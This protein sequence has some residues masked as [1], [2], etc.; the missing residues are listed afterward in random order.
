MS[1]L[2]TDVANLARAW[3]LR[4]GFTPKHAPKLTALDMA[5]GGRNTT[6]EERV[7]RA[8]ACDLCDTLRA[9]PEGRQA[10]SDLGF[11]PVS[12]DPKGE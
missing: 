8:A 11:E 1:D 10:L 3:L 9:A 2:A 12:Q 5:V 7:L 6:T 4:S